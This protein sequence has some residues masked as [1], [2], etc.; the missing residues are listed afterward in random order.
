MKKISSLFP[1]IVKKKRFFFR[2]MRQHVSDSENLTDRNEKSSRISD[3]SHE[4]GQRPRPARKRLL[5]IF[6]VK[7]R[8]AARARLLY[9]EN[10]ANRHPCRKSRQ[11]NMQQHQKRQSDHKLFMLCFMTNKLHGHI[12][13]KSTAERT[14]PHQHR[15]GDAPLRQQLCR[16]LVI[17]SQNQCHCRNGG[18]INPQNLLYFESLLRLLCLSLYDF[19]A[20]MAS[21]LRKEI[22]I[23]TKSNT[24]RLS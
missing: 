20:E 23:P 8:N 9:R 6:T 22:E 15:F 5:T 10:T 7:A 13:G 16:K 19:C 4:T 18:K 21:P 14:D 2:N 1:R 11:E 12:H 3:F 24:S 17:K